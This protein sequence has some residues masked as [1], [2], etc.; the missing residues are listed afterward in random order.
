[1][2]TCEGRLVEPYVPLAPARAGLFRSLRDALRSAETELEHLPEYY[3][4]DGTTPTA[5]GCPAGGGTLR[6]PGTDTRAHVRFRRCGFTPGV[7]LTGTGSYSYEDDR[8]VLDVRLDGR[9]HGPVRYVRESSGI[10]V[11]R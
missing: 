11:T 3:Y 9:W 10:T 5:V 6:L 1:M 2:S 4:W 8:F 7:L